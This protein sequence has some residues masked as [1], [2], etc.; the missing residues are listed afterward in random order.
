MSYSYSRIG[1]Q[2][3]LEQTPKRYGNW[4]SILGL[5]K[6]AERFK[7][8]LVQG[9][10]KSASYVSVM[11]WIAETAAQTLEQTGRLTVVVQDNGPIHTSKMVRE[12][13]AR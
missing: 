1:Q 8:A 2:K 12:Q 3:Y 5:W 9:G 10:F 6:P 13:W 11:D 7:Y 4:I